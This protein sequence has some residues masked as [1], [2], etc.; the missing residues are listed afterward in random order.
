MKSKRNLKMQTREI[1]FISANEGKIEFYMDNA[2]VFASGDLDELARVMPEM[3]LR[4]AMASSSM[5]FA[6]EYGFA[7]HSG[8]YDLL[9]QA[10]EMSA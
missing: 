7:T 3:D 9:T 2:L 10:I 4:D 5:D 6:D 1:T 8:A